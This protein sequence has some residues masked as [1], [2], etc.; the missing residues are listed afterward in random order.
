[1][2]AISDTLSQGGCWI[3]DHR[4][5]SDSLCMLVDS[6]LQLGDDKACQWENLREGDEGGAGKMRQ[7]LVTA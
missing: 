2:G 6:E 5:S 3:I 7:F 1:M 4:G